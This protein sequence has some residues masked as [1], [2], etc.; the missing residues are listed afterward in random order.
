MAWGLARAADDRGVDILQHTEVTGFRI[1]SGRIEGVETSR[2]FIAAPKVGVA[3]AGHSSVLA[4]MAGFRMP[5]QSR[6]LQALVS[7]PLKPIFNTVLMSATVH[8]YLSQSDR[9][10][11]VMGAG[12]DGYNSYAQ[13][14]SP[15]ILE[16]ML[17]AAVELFPIFSRVKMMRQWG[18]IVDICPDAS[19]IVGKTP[20]SGLFFNC[21]W[22]TG[23][24]KAIP[25]SGFVFAHT[26]AQGEPHEFAAPFSLD[27]FT[28][29]A[30]IDEHGASGVAH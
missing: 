27:R 7:E 16:D 11:L 28:T 12:T 17:A 5:I 26:L 30:L 15:M 25:G 1:Q 13:R 23:G 6:P 18:G 4:G 22:G 9:G 19:P 10:E 3:V 21:G 29:G 24:F 2:G 20:I 8:V 14:G